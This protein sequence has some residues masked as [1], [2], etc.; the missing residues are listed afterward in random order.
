M[1]PRQEYANSLLVLKPLGFLGNGLTNPL[2]SLSADGLVLMMGKFYA[3]NYTGEVVSSYYDYDR[4]GW[5]Q[6]G[7]N[8]I[9]NVANGRFGCAVSLSADGSTIV[10]GAPNADIKSLAKCLCTSTI[11]RI[12]NG[13]KMGLSLRNLPKTAP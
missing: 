2:F 1:C 6:C 8:I 3:K 9:G 11:R 7:Q 10:V 4:G 12:R 5:I 13:F